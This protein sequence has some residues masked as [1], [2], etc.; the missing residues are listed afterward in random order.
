MIKS[1]IY[2]AQCTIERSQIYIGKTRQATL[3]QRIEQHKQQAMAGDSTAFHEALREYG[4]RNWEWKILAECDSSQEF[5]LEKDF[6]KRFGATPIDLLNVVHKPKSRLSEHRKIRSKPIAAQKNTLGKL[7]LRASGR[8]KPV[9]NLSSGKVYE[10]ASLAAREETVPISAIRVCCKHG[11][12][13]SNG[14]RFAY[15]DLENKPILKEGHSKANYLGKGKTPLRVKNLVTDEV[16]NN[17]LEASQRYK[18]S[19]SSIDGCARGKYMTALG[20]YVFCFLDQDG[21]ECLT[22]RHLRGLEKIKNRDRFLYVAW[23]LTDIEMTKPLFFKSLHELCDKLGIKHPSHVKA[24]CEGE[25]SHVEKWRI[26]YYDHDANQPKLTDRHKTSKVHEIRRV[27]CLNDGRVFNSGRQA[28]QHYHLNGSQIL[29]VASG[30]A[31]SVRFGS[32]RLR[33]AFLDESGNEILTKK[34]KESLSHR[35]AFQVMQ[36]SNGVIYN[37]LAEYCRETGIPRKAAERYVKDNTVNLLGYEFVV[38][39]T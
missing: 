6:I 17:V 11:K 32:M 22:D 8:Q 24:V 14:T 36:L 18:I 23:E 28:G 26:A 10:S 25:R 21:K 29:L 30:K 39:G 1:I 19:K 3:S 27:K 37:S 2:L 13:L 12:M 34:H 20:K 38:L 16:F 35:G 15:L 7:I 4:F 31:K 9:I 5:S 33:F